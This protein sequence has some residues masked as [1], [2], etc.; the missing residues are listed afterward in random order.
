MHKI[1]ILEGTYKI[2][3]KDVELAGMVFPMVEE[4]KVGSQGGYVTVDGTAVAGFPDR[5]IKI[6][7]DSAESYQKVNS[8]TKV[9]AREESDE[10]VIDRLRERFDILEDMTKACKKGDVRAMIVSGPPGVGKSFGVEKVLGKHEL[11]AQLGDRPAKYQV[12]KGAMSAIG[13]YCKLYNYA[14][15]DNVLVFDD[16]D[17]ILQEDLSLNILKAA[18]DSKKTRRIHWNTDSFKLRN[19]GVPDSFEFKGSAIFI[20]N[21]KF[22]NVKS[23]KM[24]DHLEAI[25]S[26][27][28]YIDLTIDTE[29]E[30]MLRIKQIVK[31]GMLNQHGLDEETHERVVDFIDINKKEL[32]ELSLRTVLKVADLAKAFPTNWEA[33]AENTVLRRA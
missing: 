8:N 1:K 9:T 27:C 15:K 21:I 31:D 11:I 28:H 19:E 14:D 10:E 20:T 13:L 6:R 29:R 18:L 30:K 7:V 33:M 23:K 16:C 2:R 12:V 5:N 3:G 22:D 26:R 32:R 17:S 25:E 24:R 4:F